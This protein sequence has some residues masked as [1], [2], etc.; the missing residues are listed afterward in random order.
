MKLIITSI[1]YTAIILII[2]KK[3]PQLYDRF[4]KYNNIIKSLWIILISVF[5]YLIGIIITY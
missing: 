3:D 4:L 5:S 1:I 2:Y